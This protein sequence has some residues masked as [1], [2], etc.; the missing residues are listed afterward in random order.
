MKKMIETEDYWIYE[1]KFIFKP[2]FDISIDIYEDI[3]CN[4][5][6]LIFSDYNDLDIFI[7][8]SFISSLITAFIAFTQP[9]RISNDSADNTKSSIPDSE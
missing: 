2:H 8:N 9:F 5:N 7:F 3:I 6:E 4:Y 1:D